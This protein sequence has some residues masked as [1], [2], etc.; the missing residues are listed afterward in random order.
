MGPGMAGG[1]VPGIAPSQPP[2]PPPPRVHLPPT[3]G[4]RYT[5]YRAPAPMYGRVNMVVGLRSVAQLTLGVH[6]SGFIGMTEVYNPVRIDGINNHYC[7]PGNKKA[8][9]SNPWTGPLSS[10]QWSIKHQKE[11]ILDYGISEVGIWA[12]GGSSQDQS[13]GWSWRVNLRGFWRS[14]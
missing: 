2:S 6:F 5:V 1:W 9:V 7:I 13:G 12:S 11:P 10:Q 3:P 8:G 4:A 14:I